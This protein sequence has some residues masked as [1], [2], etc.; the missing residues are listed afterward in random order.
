MRLETIE[1][2]L[3]EFDFHRVQKVMKAL[4]WR[5]Y[6]TEDVFP[7]VADLRRQARSLLE[8]VYHHSDT[9]CITMGCGGFEATRLMGVGDLNKYLSLKFVVEEGNNHE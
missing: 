4:D 3:D 5:W 6:G 1:N 9:T 8:D 7:S 2:I